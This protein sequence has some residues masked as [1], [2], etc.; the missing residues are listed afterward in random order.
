MNDE[1][2]RL[3]Q[4]V[5]DVSAGMRCYDTCTSDAHDAEC[6]V[7]HPVEA[8]RLLRARLEDAQSVSDEYWTRIYD[9]SRALRAIDTE[10]PASRD[11]VRA[12]RLLDGDELERKAEREKRRGGA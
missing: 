5:R 2:E 6:P 9:A 11:I 4:F 7:A 10:A 12:M 3:R 1:L 8:W